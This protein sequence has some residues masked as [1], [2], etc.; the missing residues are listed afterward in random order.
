MKKRYIVDDEKLLSKWNFKKNHLTPDQ[1]TTGSRK[2][3]WWICDKGHEW[4]TSVSERTRGYGCPYCSGQRV[5]V[6]EN[7]LATLNPYLAK[8]WHPYKNGD[9]TPNDVTKGSHIKVWWVCKIGHEWE[10]RVANR[11]NGNGCPHCR[12]AKLNK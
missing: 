11:N 4:E 9:L 5:A 12:K 1:I 6:G 7:D 8:E 10:S 2:K 3:V